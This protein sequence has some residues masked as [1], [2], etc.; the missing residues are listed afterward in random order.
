MLFRKGLFVYLKFFYNL[1][2]LVTFC[3]RH[4]LH[5]RKKCEIAYMMKTMAKRFFFSF[6]LFAIFPNLTQAQIIP[7]S[8]FLKVGVFKQWFE[9]KSTL[10]YFDSI[11]QKMPWATFFFYKGTGSNELYTITAKHVI[12]F[13][14]D[15]I[16]DLRLC[17]NSNDGLQSFVYGI[18]TNKSTIA[19]Y[20]PDSLIDL[21]LLGAYNIKRFYE[22]IHWF[23]KQD[24]LMKDELEKLKSGQPVFLIG[25]NLD[26]ATFKKICYL[27]P[28]GTLDKVFHPPIIKTDTSNGFKFKVQIKIKITEK[29]GLSGG[30]VLIKINDKWKILGIV[31]CGNTNHIYCTPA[32]EILKMVPSKDY[33]YLKALN[34]L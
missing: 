12:Q 5:S 32:Y 26:S 4:S 2:R 16:R 28:I 15:S 10:R 22:G 9:S 31:N 34:Q 13:N 24:I 8:L 14:S 33:L 29:K 18:S 1:Q 19:S 20:H 6:M 21:A 25:L 7:D 30:P 3:D 27:N 17:F 23:T 11:H